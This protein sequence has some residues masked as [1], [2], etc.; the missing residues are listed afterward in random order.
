MISDLIPTDGDIIPSY[1]H[2]VT[3]PYRVTPE[4]RL[5]I[6][7][8]ELATIEMGKH[9]I[10]EWAQTEDFKFICRAVGIRSGEAADYL[11]KQNG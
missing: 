5:W 7:V 3:A 9:Q 4:R 6:R 10:M 1:E 2:S 8:L 11:R